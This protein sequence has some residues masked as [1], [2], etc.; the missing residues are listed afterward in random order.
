MKLHAAADRWARCNQNF[1][2]TR[3][4]SNSCE[5]FPFVQLASK[6]VETKVEISQDMIQRQKL[7]VPSK[8][9]GCNA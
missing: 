5:T 9:A 8:R 2:G 1:M 3:S 6:R 4:Q 7:S